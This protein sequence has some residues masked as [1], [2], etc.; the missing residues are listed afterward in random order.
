MNNRH[1]GT[2]E[3]I[4]AHPISANIDFKDV[5]HMLTD[6]GAEIDSRSK[7]RIGVTL[8]GHTAA[9]HHAHH[10]LTMKDVVQIPHFLETSGVSPDTVQR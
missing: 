1:R 4:F 2:L 10:R 8:N 7:A 5:E 6:L 3:A 9:F